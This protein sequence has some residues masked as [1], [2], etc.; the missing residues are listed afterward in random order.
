MKTNLRQNFL[1]AKFKVHFIGA[2]LFFLSDIW[3][4]F[5]F[6]FVFKFVYLLYLRDQS[7]REHFLLGS[8]GSVELLSNKGKPSSVKMDQLSKVTFLKQPWRFECSPSNWVWKCK[9][10]FAF[11]LWVSL[12]LAFCYKV[13]TLIQRQISSVKCCWPSWRNSWR[14]NS[15][16]PL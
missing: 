2:R 1:K 6:V 4:V 12:N 13:N 8:A 15:G 7:G 10:M 16:D 5:V 14:P 11:D 9:Q 3:L